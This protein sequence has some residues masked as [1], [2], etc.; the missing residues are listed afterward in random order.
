MS[1]PLCVFSFCLGGT[2]TQ[3]LAPYLPGEALV[4]PE[5]LL[6]W[7]F[8]VFCCHQTTS[9]HVTELELIL[10]SVRSSQMT[11]LVGQN[12]VFMQKLSRCIRM[13]HS[14]LLMSFTNIGCV[15]LN[16]ILLQVTCQMS[17]CKCNVNL[18]PLRSAFCSSLPLKH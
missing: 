5:P 15:L 17:Q 4:L 6:S 11:V 16:H 2:A 10:L 12:E 18:V 8:H 3:C 1:C 14:L 13:S 9:H 7:C